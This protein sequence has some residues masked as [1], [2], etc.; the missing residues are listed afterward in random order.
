MPLELRPLPTNNPA[1]A[2]EARSFCLSTIKATYG[3]DYTP[4][5]HAD[6]D[7]LLGPNAHNHYA[8]ENKGCFW[9][10]QADDGTVVGTMGVRSLAYKPNF[11][12]L[13]A[14]HYPDFSQ[15]ASLWRTYLAPE[16][17]KAG[18]GIIMNSTA[19]AFARSQGYTRMFL[20][21]NHAYPRLQAYWQRLGYTH[22][23][24]GED[25]CCFDRAL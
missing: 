11:K 13:L 7:S 6:L 1:L 9:V 5:W 18:R 8:P 24:S 2:A 22:F 15:I 19:L 10:L 16:Y 17:R 21:C 20:E 14:A 25:F 3:F 23:T 4:A 12:P